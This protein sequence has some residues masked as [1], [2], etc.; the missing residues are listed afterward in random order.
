MLCL[1]CLSSASSKQGDSS[2]ILTIDLSTITSAIPFQLYSALTMVRGPSF[3]ETV[4]A[5]FS[6]YPLELV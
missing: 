4:P 2:L 3:K 5:D 1:L 6:S